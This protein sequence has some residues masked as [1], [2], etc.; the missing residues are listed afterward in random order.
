MARSL[1]MTQ[2]FESTCSDKGIKSILF[3]IWILVES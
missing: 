3:L 2:I 1:K